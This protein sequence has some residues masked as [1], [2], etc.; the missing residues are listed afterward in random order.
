MKAPYQYYLYN[1]AKGLHKLLKS[2]IGWDDTGI[3]IGRDTFYHGINVEISVQ[4]E[5]AK[6][7]KAYI[8]S[9]YEEQGIDA[10]VI[11]TFYQLN[12]RI[13]DYEL[14][15]E[16]KLNL[17]ALKIE[18][19][20]LSVGIDPFNIYTKLKNRS[21]ILIDSSKLVSLGG[22]TIQAFS[23]E[24][25]SVLLHSKAILKQYIGINNPDFD[26]SSTQLAVSAIGSGILSNVDVENIRYVTLGFS[27]AEIDEI[28]DVNSEIATGM[29]SSEPVYILKAEE[30][31][32]YTFGI[33]MD[34][35]MKVS[36]SSVGPVNV[37]L[38]N[39]SAGNGYYDNIR[40]DL[41]FRIKN[42]V[43]LKEEFFIRTFNANG[44]GLFNLMGEE[45]LD[46]NLGRDLVVDDEVYIY[47]KL[48]AFSRITKHPISPTVLNT[49]FESTVRDN[50]K[51][52]I[53]GTTTSTV[54]RTDA[55]ALMVFE[56]FARTLQSITDTQDPF[57]SEL[58]GRVNSEPFSYIQNGEGSYRALL[59]GFRIRQ[60]PTAERPIFFSLK[61]LYECFDSIDNIGLGIENGKIVI[62]KKEHFY[63][64]Q[65]IMLCEDA[66]EVTTTV[67][68]E[69]YWNEFEIGFSKWEN[70]EVNNLDEFNTKRSY[71]L[72]IESVKNKLIK[73][74]D[75]I[76]SGY[77][78]EFTRRQNYTLGS[79][80]DWKY[81]E[82]NFVVVVRD[83]IEVPGIFEADRAQDFDASEFAN[84]LSP[85]T[86]YNLKIDPRRNIERWG[87][88]LNGALVHHQ[89][90]KIKFAFG[91]GNYRMKD[92]LTVEASS[93]TGND[94]IPASDLNERLWIPEYYE[95]TY[96]VY[97]EQLKNIRANPYG[98]IKA[99]SR[100]K[101]YFGYIVSIK[102][103]PY[104]NLGE[105]KLLRA[106]YT[107]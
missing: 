58:Y 72:P 48:R 45:V 24:S 35:T 90:K 106:N 13:N 67:A 60:F 74:T 49:V 40:I 41:V 31:G 79:T 32:Y 57:R 15:Y 1:S 102:V 47:F 4:V 52:T 64:Q 81:D 54:V 94:D 20:K 65:I 53:Q 96:P 103:D 19:V 33:D 71:A 80:K 59:N 17:K 36:G 26:E 69:Y 8:K 84:L 10:E 2:P 92:K 37:K 87:N 39:C 85:E 34:Y 91:Q 104:K 70:E 38:D 77:T 25:K 46:Y 3:I 101:N 29:G 9:V 11:F 78:I 55:Q 62:E 75:Y 27:S 88:V 86:S 107:E 7:A 44:C 5:F 68:Q 66:A 42:G 97:A 76:A 56:A 99:T 73:I 22:T 30:P 95:F 105:F 16:G 98:I 18:D 82:S 83:G 43:T 28:Q 61:D 63:R 100:N 12:K 14:F 89:D 50:A 51:L 93:K 21:E 6:D 23:E